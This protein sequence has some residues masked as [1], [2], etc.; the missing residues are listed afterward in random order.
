LR[1]VPDNQEVLCDP[2]TDQST[3]LPKALCKVKHLLTQ[4]CFNT[5]LIIELLAY[6][7]SVRNDAAI[8]YH[9]ADIATAND[10]PLG[11]C[12]TITSSQVLTPQEAPN[13]APNFK[14]ALVGQQQVSKV[15]L[16]VG[17]ACWLEC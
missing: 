11:V 7:S 12:S 17:F 15:L 13:F 4:R 8:Q 14:A 1:D 5:G 6:D 3:L 9:F 2:T 16:V 10:A